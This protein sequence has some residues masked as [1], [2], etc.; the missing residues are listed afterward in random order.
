MARRATVCLIAC[1]ALLAL[2]PD[3]IAARPFKGEPRIDAVKGFSYPAPHGRRVGAL[4][5]AR[6]PRIHRLAFPPRTRDSIRSRAQVKVKLTARGR[7]IAGA[8]ESDALPLGIKRRSIHF[9][10]LVLFSRKESAAILGARGIQATTRAT[11]RVRRK[12]KTLARISS[13]RSRSLGLAKRK[14][15]PRV[16]NGCAIRP[17]T[18]CSFIDL[19]GAELR[20]A[21]LQGADLRDANLRG[22]DLSRADLG[23]ANLAYANLSGADLSH[24]DLVE[25]NLT[26]ANLTDANL[27]GADFEAPG[28]GGGGT[29][30]S[31]GDCPT[32]HI[33]AVAS[34]LGDR[35]PGTQGK[36]WWLS[37]NNTL[38]ADWL[39]QTPLCWGEGGCGSGPLPPSA[40]PML[41]RITDMIAG[42]QKSVDFSGLWPPPDGPF[43]DAI[44]DGLRKA[45]AAGNTP[46]LRVILGT[47]PTQYSDT[48]FQAWVNALVA[49]VGTSLPVQAAAMSTYRQTVPP[50]ATSWNHSKI[51]D[52]DGRSAIVGGMNYWSK[53]YLQVADPANDVSMTVDGPAAADTLKFDDVLWG[54]ICANRGN[55]TYV[56]FKTNQ[57]SGCVANASTLPATDTGDVPILTLGRLGNGID[58]PGEAGRE[59]PPIPD[60]PVKGS[61]CTFYQRQVSDT[62][63]NR[64]YEYRNPG[65]TGLRA[66]IGSASQSIFLSQQDLLGC[67]YNVEALFDER[68]FTAL[69]KKII[70]GVPITIVLSADGATAAGD[71]YSNGNPI[72][73]VATTLVKVV[74]ALRPS[75][76][77]RD[78]VCKD[79]GLA[80]IRTVDSNKWPNGSPFANHAKVVSV[81]DSAFYIGSEN[82]YPARLQELG[83]LVESPQA[84]ATLKSAYLDPLWQRSRA[85]ALIDPRSG[86]CRF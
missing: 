28:C 71:S 61:A 41:S 73:Q 7:R 33:D 86:T 2:A 45:V 85:N 24:A 44:V 3:A 54:W 69:G 25:A 48:Q 11:E 8:R 67:V 32:P 47:P 34:A 17:D 83:L 50:V 78:L 16:A 12:D 26:D 27:T 74:A 29:P 46:T 57:I 4:I 58:V 63:T 31:G 6:Y 23:R 35:N 52:V 79:V 36:V 66:L 14:R 53:D 9:A 56:A 60:A 84:A 64:E 82:L 42:A 62:N 80:P 51:I 5:L 19:A 49:D 10:H 13:K 21:N 20:D 70:Q 59:S 1:F 77:A 43:R 81:D 22:A 38:P 72:K 55:S 15:S 76:N 30:G 40:K 68:V 65:E 75:G 18:S 37:K 39:L